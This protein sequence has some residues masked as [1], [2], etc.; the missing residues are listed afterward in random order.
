[1]GS[2]HGLTKVIG[3]EK[4]I[5]KLA[6]RRR[7]I[8]ALEKGENRKIIFSLF[9]KPENSFRN[10]AT[11][12][13]SPAAKTRLPVELLLLESPNFHHHHLPLLFLSQ[14]ISNKNRNFNFSLLLRGVIDFSIYSQI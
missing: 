7:A 13:A 9:R 4:I 12:A 3:G 10:S 14:C 2:A 6:G 11:A 8:E 5:R 1:M